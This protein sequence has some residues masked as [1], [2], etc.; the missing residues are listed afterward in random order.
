[1]SDH[2]ARQTGSDAGITVIEV[3]VVLVLTSLLLGLAAA[4]APPSD[5]IDPASDIA[6]LVEQARLDA[7]LTGTNA[8]LTV[9]T[10][11]VRYG[12]REIHFDDGIVLATPGSVGTAD[13]V[14]FP[15]G[16]WFGATL[17]V[18]SSQAGELPLALL[19]QGRSKP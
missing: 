8:I 4:S 5:A 9:S 1:M 16:T 18:S 12:D 6:T 14:F 13:L 15:D 11:S 17:T 19:P 3:L 2:H 10:N 7:M